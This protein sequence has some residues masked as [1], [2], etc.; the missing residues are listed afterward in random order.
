MSQKRNTRVSEFIPSPIMIFQGFQETTWKLDWANG[1][2]LIR[3]TSDASMRDPASHRSLVFFGGNCTRR[4]QMEK[5]GGRYGFSKNVGGGSRCYIE[6]RDLSKADRTAM[7]SMRPP[8][9]PTPGAPRPIH[10]GKSGIRVIII[11]DS[12]SIR[13][14]LSSVLKNCGVDP[15]DVRSHIPAAFLHSSRI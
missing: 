4:A 10:E 7:T 9:H 2:F 15:A 5:I 6:L 11:D 8:V 14:T 13:R 1:F 3:M 12:F